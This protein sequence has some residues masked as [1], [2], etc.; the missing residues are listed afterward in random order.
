M[1]NYQAKT[2]HPI[3]GKWETADWYDDYF[4]KHIYGVKFPND[5]KHYNADEFDMPKED[6]TPISLDTI[7]AAV[8]NRNETTTEGYV[9]FLKDT[10]P[11]TIETILAE[12]EEE[13]SFKGDWGE[14]K[15][16]HFRATNRTKNDP[17]VQDDEVYTD[18]K[19]FLT[20][21][22]TSLR[23]QI[24]KEDMEW[25][26]EQKMAELDYGDNPRIDRQIEYYNQ[27]LQ[28]FINHKH[29]QIKQ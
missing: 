27:A 28:D 3:T 4:G 8:K 11:K 16:T 10:T 25:A 1:S 2:K 6:D 19:K 22:L 9:G 14:K 17:I 18:L 21:A 29:N 5:P 20:Q 26:E 24:A 13:F 23:N 15:F 12:F 7:M